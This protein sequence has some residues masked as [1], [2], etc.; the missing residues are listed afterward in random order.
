[1]L[2]MIWIPGFSNALKM[3]RSAVQIDDWTIG[4][5]ARSIN[6][7]LHPLSKTI[8]GIGEFGI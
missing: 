4:E 8:R 3:R 2:L 5:S 6:S 1:M 7:A